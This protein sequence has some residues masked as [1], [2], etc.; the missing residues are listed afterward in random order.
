MATSAVM[1]LILVALATWS[2]WRLPALHPAQLWTI[3]WALAAS[4]YLLDL[5]PYPMLSGTTAFIVSAASLAFVASAVG[6]EL[7]A[8]HTLIARHRLRL[9]LEP[10]PD[11][12]RRAAALAV[13]L[14]GILLAAFLSQVALRYGVH[15]AIISSSTVR[16][17]IEAGSLAI[18]IKYVYL[19]I[20]ATAL[21]AVAASSATKSNSRRRWATAG[22]ASVASLYFST[23][24]STIVAAAIVG[25]VTYVLARGW[26]PSRVQFAAG[27]ALIGVLALLVFSI[28]GA[29]IGKTFA[30]NAQLQAVPS[31]FREHRWI[32]DLALPYQ[33]ASAPI[34]ALD[35]LVANA[36][37]WGSTHGCA[38]LSEA[39][40]ILA[41]LGVDVRG[42]SRIRPFTAEPVAWNTYTALDAPILDGGLTL[43]VPIVAAVG[44]LMG[45]LW[46]FARAR[47]FPGLVAYGILAPAAVTASGQFNFTAPHLLGAI[48]IAFGVVGIV[49]FVNRGSRASHD[50]SWIGV[51]SSRAKSSALTDS[52]P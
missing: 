4:L 28:G 7:L 25:V 50:R 30:N 1:G 51:S 38:S 33:Y 20:A 6:G 42:V 39:C 9:D 36:P 11:Q 19:A 35:T 13:A 48:I 21:C 16:N 8:R 40:R 43:A 3:P 44:F 17:A 37:V 32:S 27:V 14:T 2:F 15:A 10:R 45:A 47:L 24:R 49:C 41:R 29:L 26:R 23:G 5:L 12:I 22:T 52:R 46:A 18:T 31:V 34:S